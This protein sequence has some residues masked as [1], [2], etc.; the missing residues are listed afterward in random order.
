MSYGA[1]D[2]LTQ[3]LIV[4][5]RAGGTPVRLEISNKAGSLTGTTGI[6]GRPVAGWLYLIANGPS[7]TPV[8]TLRSNMDGT[9]TDPHIPPGSY[10]SVGFEHRRS[11]DFTDA[12]VLAKFGMHV[13]SVSI[14]AGN[15]SS[16][17]LDLVPESELP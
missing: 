12:E 13:Q 17:A 10:Q 5:D 3:D 7:A 16:L 11:A 14:V 6:G 4:A 8:L 2:L 1:S 15:N 9:F